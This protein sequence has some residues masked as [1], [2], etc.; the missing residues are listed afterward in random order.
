MLSGLRLDEALDGGSFG[1]DKT[2]VNWAGGLKFWRR[3]LS[4]LLRRG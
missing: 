4:N 2:F 1:L 3:L